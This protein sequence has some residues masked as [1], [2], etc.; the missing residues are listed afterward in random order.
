MNRIA[1]MLSPE[2]WAALLRAGFIT[3][4]YPPLQ[5]A[6]KLTEHERAW[7]ARQMRERPTGP[8]ARY[9]SGGPLPP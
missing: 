5:E 4:S 9:L 8:Y 2:E 6:L 7:L 1:D 3:A